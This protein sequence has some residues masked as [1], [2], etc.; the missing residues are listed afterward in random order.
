[1]KCVTPGAT[2]YDSSDCAPTEYCEFSLGDDDAGAPHPVGDASCVNSSLKSGRC[3]AKPPICAADAGTSTGGTITCLEQ[4]EYHP[5]TAFDPA[6]KY[7]WGGPSTPATAS[8]VMMT[9]IVIELDDD[10]CDGKVDQRDIPEI[11]FTTFASGAYT[12]SG[13]LHA[14]SVVSGAVV[15]K[16]SVPAGA[17]ASTQIAGGDIDGNPGNEIV[18]CNNGNVSAYHG[19]GSPMWTTA[20]AVSCFMPA[21]ADLDQDGKPEVVVEGAI[22]NGATG[23]VLHALTGISSGFAISDIDGDGKLDV[24]GAS[25]ASHA[26]G[27]VFA[28]TGLGG[29]WPAVADFNGDG[30]PEVVAVDYGAHAVYVWHYDAASPTKA[31][32]VRTDINI[33]GTLDPALCA[34]GT[35]GNTLGGGP[36]TI[37]DFNADHVPDVALAGGI[38]YAVLDGSK[39]MNATIASTDP[40]LFLFLKQTHDCS[41]AATGSSLFDFNGDGNVEV[42]YADEF[43]LHVYDGKTGV[44]E[45][46]ICNTNGTLEE[47]PVVADVDGDGQADLIVVSNAYAETCP[48]PDTADAGND[49]KE[50]G[51]R[52]Y[53]SKSG[54]WVQTRRVWNEHAYHVTNV[55]EDGTIPKIEANNWTSPGL[56]DFRQ[57]KQPGN[58]FAAPDAIVTVAPR[59][60]GGGALVAT[61][62]N[63]GEAA[64]P[65]GVVVGFYQGTPGSGTLLGR[66]STTVVLYP[67]ESQ[68]VVLSGTTVSGSATI[69]AVVDDG[70]PKH[71]WHE[72]RADN[73]T[74]AAVS[75]A[76]AGPR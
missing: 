32:V 6:L 23:A 8:D 9:P 46:T 74:S 19:D 28:T 15:D 71:P 10:N 49:A 20:T 35:A 24:V 27:T 4:C 72:C 43:H 67:A 68:D 50:S 11:V 22:L 12:S 44:E 55:N 65:A 45:Y 63:I 38:G 75:A 61:V 17:T 18:V 34:V 59:C 76:C 39:L 53:E 52:I 41:S 42:A 29:S 13:T 48:D 2:C 58:E 66:A 37:G 5:T 40:S 73:D 31:T 21:I 51:I 25:S 57:N 36:A 47:N 14:I 16:W 64:L 56:N 62:R 30:V 54:S 60:P 26:D 1:S 70:S 7:T 69:Y 33:N 3:L